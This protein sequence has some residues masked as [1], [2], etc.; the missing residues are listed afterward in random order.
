MAKDHHITVSD[1][2]MIA[3][4]HGS[5]TYFHDTSLLDRF[6]RMEHIRADMSSSV[7]G[8]LDTHYYSLSHHYCMLPRMNTRSSL[9]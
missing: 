4:D 6:V 8:M 9:Q 5:I 7:F 2:L 1:M 3:K